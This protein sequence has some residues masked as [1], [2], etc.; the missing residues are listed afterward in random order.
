[1]AMP[2]EQEQT[3]AEWQMWYEGAIAKR[4]A[5]SQVAKPCVARAGER[6]KTVVGQKQLRPNF[7]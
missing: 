5:L 4:R 7:R 6:R 2:Q 3:V 1:M